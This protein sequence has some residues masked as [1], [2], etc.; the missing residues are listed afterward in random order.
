VKFTTDFAEILTAFQE[1]SKLVVLGI[2]ISRKHPD[3]LL[4]LISRLGSLHHESVRIVGLESMNSI[5]KQ[6]IL[7]S[8]ISL[9][10][11]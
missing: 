9:Q 2:L 11:L 7:D 5:I 4:S 1:I 10:G 3:N 6:I 8:E